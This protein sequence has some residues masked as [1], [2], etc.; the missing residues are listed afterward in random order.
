MS[1][2]VL[3]GDSIFDN[4]VYVPGKP[5][6]I[7]QVR[8]SL[9]KGWR[10]TL[11]AVDGAMVEDVPAQLAKV[12]A[13]ATHLVLSVG[14][15]DAL[16]AVHLLQ[17]PAVTVGEAM[18]VL[19]EG[20]REFETRYR[21]TLRQVLA[22]GKPT[23][24]C[25]VYDSVPGLELA[26]RTALR[27]FNE[28]IT[29]TAFAARLPLIDLRLVC[30]N[31]NDYSS[32]SPIEP[33]ATGGAKIAGPVKSFSGT[34]SLA[35]RPST[36]DR[37]PSSPPSHPHPFDDFPSTCAGYPVDDDCRDCVGRTRFTRRRR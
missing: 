10:A 32:V 12:P 33:S 3:L 6:V 2:V 25:T 7:E 37:S 22:V 18:L 14:G 4:A 27:G 9:S 26:H 30:T 36:A 24:I 17:E 34:T 16:S 1:H 19:G 31:A 23:A 8:M 13:D 35:R 20:L 29:R 28:I 21:D 15:N 5:A 11:C